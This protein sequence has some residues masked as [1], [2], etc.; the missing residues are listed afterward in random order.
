MPATA[1]PH[2]ADPQGRRDRVTG[3]ADRLILHIGPRKTGTTYLQ[4]V[5]QQLS[6]SLAAQG[7]LYPTD[8]RG[9][10]DYNH[11]GAVNDLTH[12][13]ESRRPERWSDKLGDDWGSLVK[14]VRS[15]DGTVVLSAEMIGGLRPAAA[16]QLLDGLG[17]PATDV[18][19]TMRDLGRI[20]P[21]SWQQHI[22]NTHTQD[23][24]AYLGR[25]ARERGTLPPAEMQQSWDE[26]RHQTFWRSYA[27]G[28]LVR[29]WQSLA[30]AD[31][32]TVVTLPP[33][34]SSSTLLWDRF[35]AALDIAALPEVAPALPPFVAN[36]GSTEPEA[37]LLH[38]MNAEAKRRGWSRRTTNELQQ[39]LLATGLLDR[40]DRGRPLLLPRKFLPQARAW[41]DTDIADLLTTGVTVH[42]SVE[43]LRV[44]DSSASE[45]KPDASAAA[46]AGAYAAVHALE[47]EAELIK[48]RNARQ[49]RVTLPGRVLRRM[50]RMVEPPPRA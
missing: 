11:V 9:Q 50:I 8:Y 39:R 13:E 38:A 45:G 26:E 20:F 33:A 24:K 35:R 18:V 1:T 10:D 42:G 47:Q 14:V 4:R 15:W 5:L 29:R 7:V 22:R 30:G 34:G 6:A 19:I 41:A 46:A 23:Y 21:S 32:V 40:P 48:R 3:V 37:L 43:D 27:Y 25:R 12:A 49:A 36:I 31:R 44:L 2:S 17:V 28:A 16:R